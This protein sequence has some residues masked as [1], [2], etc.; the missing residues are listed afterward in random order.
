MRVVADVDTGIDDALALVWLAAR[1]RAGEIDLHVTTSAGNTTAALAARNSMEVLDLCGASDV[2]VVAGAAVP[3]VLPLTT[4][5]ETH[6]PEGLGYWVPAV[7]EMDPVSTAAPASTAA[8]AVAAWEAASPDHLLVAG[9]ATNLAYAVEHHPGILRRARVTLMCGAF[10]YPGNTTPTAEWNA[11]VDPHALAFAV[12]NWPEGAEPPVIC[13]LNVTEQVVLTPERLDGWTRGDTSR[14]ARMLRDALRFYFEFH[15]SVGVG[16]V[17]QIHDL[18]AAMVML[19]AVDATVRDATV[20]VATDPE[21]V[22]GTT[23]ADWTGEG[24]TGP[25]WGRPANARVLTGLDPEEVFGRFAV[26]LGAPG[27][28]G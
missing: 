7:W 16:H 20:A 9:P 14:R 6:G 23:V 27:A 19:G 8:D 18:A 1:H 5:P 4:T 28:H 21:L 26:A 11:W 22:R 13:P 3:R 12:D 17:A 25:Y 15:E 24:G 2:P 10:L